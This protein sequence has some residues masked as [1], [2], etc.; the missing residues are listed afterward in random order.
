MA[1]Q[2]YHKRNHN[3][4]HGKGEDLTPFHSTRHHG[5]TEKNGHANSTGGS[6]GYGKGR[7]K[8]KR[9]DRKGSFGELRHRLGERER[10][11]D[12]KYTPVSKTSNNRDKNNDEDDHNKDKKITEENQYVS[13]P[14]ALNLTKLTAT[15][16]S[17]TA[18]PI[19]PNIPS[20]PSPILPTVPSGPSNSRF[21]WFKK[22][23]NNNNNYK[24]GDR[25]IDA[26]SAGKIKVKDDKEKEG[27]EN[28]RIDVNNMSGDLIEV[29]KSDQPDLIS[30][31][32]LSDIHNNN[33]SKG[34]YDSHH[35]ISNSS[36]SGSPRKSVYRPASTPSSSSR[37]SLTSSLPPR[38]HSRPVP[39][40][41][42]RQRPKPRQESY[43]S[44]YQNQYEPEYAHDHEDQYDE[45]H[46]DRER[47]HDQTRPQRQPQHRKDSP[48]PPPPPLSAPSSHPSVSSHPATRDPG[49]DQ[50]PIHYRSG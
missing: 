42:D 21:R 16:P 24:D 22:I 44:P 33:N 7:L 1:G 18:S 28:V 45:Y 25:T 2:K 15:A 8:S 49:S 40:E 46:S 20:G 14:P 3:R 41:G 19:S 5:K 4:S 37:K 48:P 10:D 23:P 13:K 29:R 30:E 11:R 26:V 38:P 31:N 43:Y 27:K 12:R 9:H 39:L 50:E 36:S 32:S 47:E 35:H 6:G 17:K 34:G